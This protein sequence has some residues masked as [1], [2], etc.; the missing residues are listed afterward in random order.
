MRVCMHLCMY[1]CVCAR[2]CVHVRTQEIRAFVKRHE[3]CSRY[4]TETCS[5]SPASPRGSPC[6]PYSLPKGVMTARNIPQSKMGGTPKVIPL[7]RVTRSSSIATFFGSI[8]HISCKGSSTGRP[9]ITFHGQI[10]ETLK[11]LWSKERRLT[12][13]NTPSLLTL[14]CLNGSL[15]TAGD[16]TLKAKTCWAAAKEPI[17]NEQ[18]RDT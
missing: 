1:I 8:L 16:A 12:S 5:M 2:T 3:V 11:L 10:P 9:T 18:N 17:L 7:R 14:E 4:L 13:T 15:K 6:K